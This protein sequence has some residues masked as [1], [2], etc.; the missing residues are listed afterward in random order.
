LDF[1]AFE[2]STTTGNGQDCFVKGLRRSELLLTNSLSLL[3]IQI[4]P[5]LP[6][7]I[8]LFK[9]FRIHGLTPHFGERNTLFFKLKV[10][11]L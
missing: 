6:I 8:V 10:T 5:G 1:Y 4:I 3:D 11:D 7:F 9:H 2:G